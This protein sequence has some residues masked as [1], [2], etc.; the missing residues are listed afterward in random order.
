VS[1]GVRL[2][3]HLEQLVVGL[4][5]LPNHARLNARGDLTYNLDNQEWEGNW[6]ESYDSVAKRNKEY[7]CDLVKNTCRVLLSRGMKGCY[8]HFMDRHT[9][10]F[11]KSRIE[12]A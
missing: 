9:E 2:L 11:F 5:L 6:G 1:L 8:V 3:D 7:F 10:Q 12:A 4:E